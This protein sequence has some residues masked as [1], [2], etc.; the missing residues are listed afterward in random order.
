[1]SES[2]GRRGAAVGTTTRNRGSVSDDN[3]GGDCGPVHQDANEERRIVSGSD[4]RGGAGKGVEQ[5]E[6]GSNLLGMATD[7]Q[8][9]PYLGLLDLGL[10]REV[11]LTGYIAITNQY[12][13]SDTGPGDVQ[14]KL[15][16]MS[17][18]V[19]LHDHQLQ[20]ILL[21]LR[22]HATTSP[23]TSNNS[24]MYSGRECADSTGRCYDSYNADQTGGSTGSGLQSTTYT[25]YTGG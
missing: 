15:D 2:R 3:S 8:Q 20:G 1:M 13:I 16:A 22:A 19:T 25:R 24:T 14:E 23:S 6:L 4:S 17:Q 11:S 5:C 10:G 9:K 12:E 18:L 21:L 7:S